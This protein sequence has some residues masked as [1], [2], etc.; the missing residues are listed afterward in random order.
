MPEDLARYHLENALRKSE[1]DYINAISELMCN[2]SS[3]KL[4]AA[5]E[6]LNKDYAALMLHDKKILIKRFDPWD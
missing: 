2:G 6:I 1:A 3:P 5:R 4:N